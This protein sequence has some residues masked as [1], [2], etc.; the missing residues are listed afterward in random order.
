[1][2]INYQHGSIKSYPVQQ[3]LPH[4]R[5]QQSTIVNREVRYAPIIDKAAVQALEMAYWR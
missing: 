1:L 3:N 2:F 5:V 4:L